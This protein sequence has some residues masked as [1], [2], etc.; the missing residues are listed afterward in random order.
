MKCCINIILHT[1]NP[2]QPHTHTQYQMLCKE[3]SVYTHTAPHSLIPT[4]DMKCCI[5]I[6]LHTHSPS[7]PHTH[8]QYQMLYK[9]TSVYTH[10]APHSL[11]PTP[12]IKCCINISLHTV[13]HS[14]IPMPLTCLH[15]PKGSRA[16]AQQL[17][18][19]EVRGGC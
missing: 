13:S 14:L 7:Q 11:I 19:S 6:S 18:S 4:P 8:T 9:E 10:T 12:N 1:H 16:L 5:D 3:T 15:S 17:A 2:S